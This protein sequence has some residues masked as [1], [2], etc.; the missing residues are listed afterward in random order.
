MDF[1]DK[2]RSYAA[3][4]GANRLSADLAG[5]HAGHIGSQLSFFW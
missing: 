5:R 2:V 4:C 1:A 3:D